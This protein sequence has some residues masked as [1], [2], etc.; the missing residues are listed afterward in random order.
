MAALY[1]R[2]QG[3]RGETTRCGHDS[4]SATL[5]TWQGKITTVLEKDG[6]FTTMIS[7][8]QGEGP[9][10]VVAQGNVNTRNAD[11]ITSDL[12]TLIGDR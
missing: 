12:G 6:S 11:E 7:G 2:M 10:I 9:R 4:I 8:K 5:E 3:S 1:G